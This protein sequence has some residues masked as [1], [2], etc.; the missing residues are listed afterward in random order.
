M[1]MKRLSTF[2][3]AYRCLVGIVLLAAALVAV[4]ARRTRAQLP[5]T[6]KVTISSALAGPM[7]DGFSLP[8][9]QVVPFD[10]ASFAFAADEPATF[11][12]VLDDSAAPCGSPQRYTHLARGRHVF[13]VYA[14]NSAGH[15]TAAPAVVRWQVGAVTGVVTGQP[16][17]MPLLGPKLLRPEDFLLS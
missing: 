17:P 5:A 7:A 2:L 15:R 13:K 11:T 10:V 1:M 12:C 3:V 6:P 14:T 16:T 9:S 8:L 4:G